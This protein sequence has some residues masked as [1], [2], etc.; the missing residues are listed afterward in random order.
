MKA[1]GVSWNPR[2]DTINF[3][4]KLSEKEIYTKRSILSNISRLFDPLGLA[5]VV[6][7]KARIALQGIWKMKKFGWDDPLPKEM[8]SNWRKLFAEIANLN[9][10]QFPRCLQPPC[11]HGSPEL[12]VFAD[13]SIFAYGAA[14]YPVWPTSTGREVR[15]VSAKARVAP[16]RQ[17]TIPRLELMAALIAT[18][19]A[20]IICNELKIKPARV[21]LWSD[22]MI[23]LAWLRSESTAFKSFVGVRVAEIQSTFESA[24]WRH[25]PSDL[26]PA[27]DL[28][29]GITV[30][31]M[32]GRWMNG[33][34]FLTKEPEE[35]PI[36]TS[37]TPSDV[38]EVK[39]RKLLFVLQSKPTAFIDPSRYSNWR[40]LCRV[41]AYCFRFIRNT[42]SHSVSAS[43]LLPEEIESAERY[44]VKEVQ[45]ELGNWK[46]QYKELPSFKLFV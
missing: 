41:T 25:V 34:V 21:V 2:T 42:K 12:H 46:E 35:W 11:V 30:S 45:R 1:L 17:T 5:S 9:T 36:E 10:V 19:L 4:V 40:R 44:W 18:R 26:N 15:L 20:K 16:L 8:Q 7:I 14:A 37:E 31:E 27:D 33:P 6:T 23:V 3:Q 29:R 24:T 32:N 39:L 38:P 28:S 22:S 13:A 43:P